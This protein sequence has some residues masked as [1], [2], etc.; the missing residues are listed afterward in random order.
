M[1]QSAALGFDGIADTGGRDTTGITTP[2]STTMSFIAMSSAARLTG[3]S[4]PSAKF[5]ATLD[6]RLPDRGFC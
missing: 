5:E 4:S 2:S 6:V 3:S 1:A